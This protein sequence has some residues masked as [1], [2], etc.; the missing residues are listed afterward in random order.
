MCE[1]RFYSHTHTE[2]HTHHSLTPCT[3]AQIDLPAAQMHNDAR[4][5]HIHNASSKISNNVPQHSEQR[6]VIPFVCGAC[7]CVRI[8]F[9]SVS[10][11]CPVR[12]TL[13]MKESGRTRESQPAVCQRYSRPPSEKK[14]TA[15]TSCI[16]VRRY[17][18]QTEGSHT[19]IGYLLGRFVICQAYI[20]IR[21]QVPSNIHILYIREYMT[22][23]NLLC[24][25][26]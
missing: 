11:L 12:E 4:A 18:I 20:C 15:H 8:P 26:I 25:H 9:V 19:F 13:T 16:I 21:A 17:T 7:L 10:T 6:C 3:S 22:E 23:Y 1:P 14:H 24:T 2:K 5:L